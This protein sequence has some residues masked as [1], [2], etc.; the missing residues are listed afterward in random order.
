MASFIVTPP[1]PEYPAA[2]AVVTGSVMQAISGVL[3][4]RVSITDHTYD[5][6]GW[7]PRTFST[8]FGAGQEAGISRLYGG[9]HYHISINTGLVMGLIIG[10]RI[11]VMRL[12]SGADEN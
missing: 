3:G 1:H 7:A 2:H 4:Y 6:R 8:I 10:T 12:H 9:I 5:F 11:G